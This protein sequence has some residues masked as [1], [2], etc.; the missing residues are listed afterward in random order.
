M[1]KQSTHAPVSIR[2]GSGHGTLVKVL[3][4]IGGSPYRSEVAPPTPGEP[5]DRAGDGQG[6]TSAHAEH[7]SDMT[8]PGNAGGAKGPDFWCA[9]EAVED[10]AI[11]D[12]PGNAGQD[13]D[14]AEIALSQGEGGAGV[15]LLSVLRQGLAG[16]HPR[17]CLCAGPRECGCAGRG[18][19]DV[20]RDRGGGP[21]GVAGSAARGAAAEDVSDTAGATGDATATGC[22]GHSRKS[23]RHDR[24]HKPWIAKQTGERSGGNPH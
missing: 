22:A 5:A 2:R 21:G 17:P 8:R 16:G 18:R 23:P 1:G 19:L 9:F 12:E 6:R 7:V 20:C 13:Q 10:E 4:V 15:P 11:G 3:R 14:A 24:S